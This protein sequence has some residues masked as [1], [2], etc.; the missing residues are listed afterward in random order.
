M[1]QQ[2]GPEKKEARPTPEALSPPIP[3]IQPMLEFMD[4][5]M[6]VESGDFYRLAV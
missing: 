6:Q 4:R 5:L 1:T 2:R 3:L